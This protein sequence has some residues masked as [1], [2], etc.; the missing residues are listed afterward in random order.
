MVV[1]QWEAL[2]LYFT[3]I[4]SEERMKTVEYIVKDIKDPSLFLYP[5]FLN[6]ILP[7]I[8]KVNLLFQRDTPTIHLLYEQVMNFYVIL[9]RRFCCRE[10]VD[11][12]ELATFNP[13]LPGNHMPLNQ[14]YLGSAV[15][16]LL[17]MNPYSSNKAIVEH[18]QLRC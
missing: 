13:D 3:Q 6:Y 4:E 14:I 12:A 1:E 2:K 16:G 8:N 18:V 10:I 7:L 9:L 15:H 17:Q 11:K 5:Y